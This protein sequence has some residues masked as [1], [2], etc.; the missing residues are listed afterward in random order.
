[1]YVYTYLCVKELSRKK[2]VPHLVIIFKILEAL[3]KR[4]EFISIML[5][6]HIV[7][8]FEQIFHKLQGCQS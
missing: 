7:K 6:L 2:V 3:M 8:Q 4:I 5:L 1:M